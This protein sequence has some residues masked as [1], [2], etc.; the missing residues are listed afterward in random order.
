MVLK[1]MD[2]KDDVIIKQGLF[3]A[4]LCGLEE[5]FCF[6]SIDVDFEESIYAGLKYFYPRLVS[7][8]YIFVHDY[9]GILPSVGKGI[10]RY[11]NEIN[12]LLCKIPICDNNGT[13]IIS[14]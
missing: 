1:K 8:G 7:G 4:S 2:N 3:P 10:N 11:Q 12:S 14:K 5:K 6:V 9:N 13:V